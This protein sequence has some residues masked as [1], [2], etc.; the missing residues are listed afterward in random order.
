MFAVTLLYLGTVGVA[1]HLLTDEPRREVSA[2]LTQHELTHHE[3]DFDPSRRFGPILKVCGGILLGLHL[4][5]ILEAVA[6][7]ATNGQC[8][9]QSFAACLIPP[10]RLSVRD[11]VDGTCVWL[12][13]W[14][15]QP[16]SDE[17]A[18]QVQR[19]LGYPM[20]GIALLILPLL[21]VEF[22]FAEQIQEHL[23]LGLTV[24]LAGAFIWLA[25][26]AEFIVMISLVSRRIQ[27]ARKHWLDLAIICLPVIAFL[28]VLRIGR[29]IKLGKLSQTAR[30]F[31]LRG[32][33]MRAWRAVLVLELVDRL[34]RRDPSRRLKLLKEQL[35]DKELEIQALR[36]EI[37]RVEALLQNTQSPA[38]I[39]TVDSEDAH[40]G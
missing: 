8:L 31:R 10:L 3:A 4:L 2:A 33:A 12:P 20:I 36:E 17:L 30:V 14:G 5:F 7:W 38:S 35:A 1:V 39:A 29:L 27:F 22:L 11:H 26:A 32:L 15:W 34:L 19:R 21:A 24:Q 28:R 16:A 37:V 9:R 25:F 6:H 18:D 23:W 13:G 40:P